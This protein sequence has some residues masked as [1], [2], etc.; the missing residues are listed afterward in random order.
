MFTPKLYLDVETIELHHGC[1]GSGE[2]AIACLVGAGIVPAGTFVV[3]GSIVLIGNTLHWLEYQGRCDD[4]V[5]QQGLAL[6]R[7]SIDKD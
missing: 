5:I 4:G 6:F 1:S 2:S 3:S 7:E